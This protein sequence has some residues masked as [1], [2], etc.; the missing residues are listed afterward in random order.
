MLHNFE[1]TS[2]LEHL[3]LYSYTTCTKIIYFTEQKA[4][5]VSESVQTRFFGNYKGNQIKR[6]GKDKKREKVNI[7]KN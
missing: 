2:R 5:L 7:D 4:I 3:F 6:G 1:I